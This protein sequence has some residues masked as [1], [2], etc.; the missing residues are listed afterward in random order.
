[1]LKI[2]L[3]CVGKTRAPGIEAAIGEYLPRLRPWCEFTL[4]PVREEK[5][6]DVVH[7]DLEVNRLREKRRPDCLWVALDERGDAVTSSAFSALLAEAREQA[8]D[9][10]FFVGG[11]LGLNDAFR[12]ECR[13]T[14][15]LSRLTFPHD[16]VRLILVEQL[17]RG[18][19]ILGG[20]AY[21]K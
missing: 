17:Y 5:V 12:R 11:P 7:R 9:I 20:S 19:S 15:A 3:V 10:Q 18:F 4:V 13:R 8:R 14:L 2:E 1:M 6:L 16:L 21:H